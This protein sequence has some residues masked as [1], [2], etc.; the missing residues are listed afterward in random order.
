MN[1]ETVGVVGC[2]LMGS[3]IAETCARHGYTTIVREISE[4]LV[5]QGRRRIDA[6]MRRGRERG[7]MSQEEYDSAWELLSFTT[8]L[9]AFDACD[10][11]IEAVVENMELKKGVFRELDEITPAHAVLASNTSSLSIT[12]MATATERRPQVVGM[13]FFN[14]VPVLPLVE[15]VRGLETGEETLATARSFGESLG[16]EIIVAK[17]N[18]GFICQFS[19]N[20]DHLPVRYS[21]PYSLDSIFYSRS[22]GGYG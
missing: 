14:P 19:H 5:E 17:D 13:H 2:G 8:E 18:P 3:G 16:K 1:I 7:K 10:L 12:E 6:S 9:S 11:V 20:P 22:R 15:L 4:D 21:I